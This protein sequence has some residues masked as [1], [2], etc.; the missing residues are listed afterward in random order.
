MTTWQNFASRSGAATTTWNYDALPRLADQQSDAERYG[1][2]HYPTPPRGGL[3]TRTVGARR[4][5]TTY[6]YNAAGDL[7]G[8][9]YST[10]PPRLLRL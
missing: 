9:T 8:V 3:Q 6:A 2:T 7:S 10:A 5:R 4:S 1:P